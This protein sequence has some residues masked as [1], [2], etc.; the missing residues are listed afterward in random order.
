[1]TWF[2]GRTTIS[3]SARKLTRPTATVVSSCRH[4][5]NGRTSSP[6]WSAGYS[7]ISRSAGLDRRSPGTAGRHPS[8]DRV[9]HPTL[10]RGRGLRPRAEVPGIRVFR[11]GRHRTA[12]RLSGS[13]Q[14]GRPDP[15]TRRRP[16]PGAPPGSW[17]QLHAEFL[18][19]DQPQLL[20]RVQAD[21]LLELLHRL[22]LRAGAEVE[23]IG[24]AAAREHVVQPAGEPGP[25]RVEPD[26]AE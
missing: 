7:A 12:I 8:G 9:L 4:L 22:D 1:M 14:G 15:R 24:H 23:R 16:S 25:D 18:L 21:G 3:P 11:P 26:V 20:P 17:V 13:Y 2:T 5:S 6:A 10:T 19:Q